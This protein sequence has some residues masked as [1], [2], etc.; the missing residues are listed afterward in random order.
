LEFEAMGGSITVNGEALLLSEAV[1]N[2]IENAINHCPRGS[3][4]RVLTAHEGGEARV[5]VEDNGPG[6]ADAQRGRA[7]E[8]FGRLD[9]SSRAGTGLG[10]AIVQEI[11]N[12]HGAQ[13]ELSESAEGGL[14]ASVVFKA[15]A[16][17]A[18]AA[19]IDANS[20]VV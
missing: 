6:I 8:R 1:K 19:T 5:V 9:G 11:A 10:L 4:I 18:M 17:Q 20:A 7:V 12:H 15:D 14:R 16:G 2:L 13:L 3:R